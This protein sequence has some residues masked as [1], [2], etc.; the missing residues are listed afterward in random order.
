MKP[1]CVHH[2]LERH[3]Q[4][5]PESVLVVEGDR[6]TSYGAIDAAANRIAH[7]LIGQG[8][9]K[10]DRIGLLAVN[11]TSYIEAY[12]GI[13]KAGAI[14]VALNTAADWRTHCELL[15]RC[16][17]KGLLCGSTVGRCAAGIDAIHD[18][19]FIL[20]DA[21][22]WCGKL[23]ADCPIRCLDWHDLSESMASDAPHVS[24]A[25][26][27]R[28]AIV[29]TSGSTGEPK[30]VTLRHANLVANTESI[31]TYLRLTAEDRAL[32]V[33]PFPYVYGKSLLNTHVAVGGSV[34]IE[35]RFL[36]P[37][38]ALDT[39]EATR[40]TGLSGVPSTFAILLNRSNFASRDLPH[41]RY[42]TQAGGA[43]APEMQRRLIDA[44]PGKEIFIMYGA[45]EASARLAYLHPRDLP[46]KIGSIGKAI[47][48]V[49]LR[50]LRENGTDADTD[51]V[52][53]LVASGENLMEGYWDDPAG[54]AEVLD[55]DG[56]HTGDLAR[57][58]ADGF[59]YIVGRK[60]EMIKSGAHRI[61]PMEI[62]EALVEHPRIDEAAVIGLPDEILGEA[63]GAFITPR[64]GESP[65]SGDII[66]WCKG[67][68]PSYKVPHR[69]EVV[70]QFRR[71]ASGKIDKQSLRTWIPDVDDPLPAG[72][73]LVS[74]GNAQA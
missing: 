7:A 59:F 48:G 6:Q 39:L 62:E 63:I 31:V 10:G 3:A 21:A 68:L 60:R 72:T 11:S 5:R 12:Y 49:D 36:F 73:N 55:A 32:V 74:A 65:V 41:L 26:G 33:L 38:Q 56:Y 67:R 30:G 29:Y 17:A 54:T 20:G 70:S 27:D 64:P 23:P 9:E 42:V 46:K 1:T 8:V 71:N 50:V 51:R 24:L 40:A 13:L 14:C 47:P 58:D 66:R 53:E 16:R 28:A 45:T 57:R 35:N 69:V 2:F 18:L 44:L 61:A 34:V 22:L 52:G 15:A 25:P 43:M 4:R 37:Q 19:E